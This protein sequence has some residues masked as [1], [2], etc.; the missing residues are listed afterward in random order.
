M[1]ELTSLRRGEEADK[2]S[3][4]LVRA[5]DIGIQRIKSGKHDPMEVHR[6]VRQMYSWSDIAE[7]TEAVYE[8]VLAA[9]PPSTIE[10]MQK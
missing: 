5:L 9:E 3:L 4:D 6:Q 10:R 2:V 7:R 1:R 8:A